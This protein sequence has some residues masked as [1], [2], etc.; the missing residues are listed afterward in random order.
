MPAKHSKAQT[1]GLFTLVL[2]ITGAI[3]SIRN[4]PTTAL[5]GSSLFFFFTLAALIFLIPV[6]LVS[7]E[8]AS[9]FS[10]EEG[11][12]YSWVK[13][14]FGESVAFFTIW[15]QWINTMVWYPTILSFIAGT[16]AY[17]I[18]PALADHKGYLIGVILITFWSL[19][20][21]SLRGLKTSAFFAGFCAIIGMIFPIFLIIGLGATWLYQGHPLAIEFN[22]ASL[23]PQWQTGQSWASLTAIM[24][25]FLG[26]ELAAVHV[27]QI[28][29]PQ[30]QFPKAIFFSVI[31]IL[32]T[33]L[34][35]SLSIAVVLPKKDINLVAGVMQAFTQFLNA[36]HLSYLLPFIIV[37][38]LLGSLGGMINW[39]ISPAKGMLMAATHGFL[40]PFLYQLNRHGVAAR[41]L[42][43]QAV[44]V[45]LLCSCFLLFPQINAIYW[46][47]TDL[48]TELYLLMYVL[49]FI[50]AIRLKHTHAHLP[51]TFCIPGGKIGYYLTCFL[52]LIGC[53][54]TLIIGFIP[55]D[56]SIDTGSAHYFQL[57]FSAGIVLM[58]APTFFFYR[59]KKQSIKKTQKP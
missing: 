53:F 36:F 52:G 22:R 43:I 24:T 7:A 45:T 51:R 8:L 5:F 33:M 50:A 42:L 46:L 39:I 20:L 11:G 49:M 57:I 48:S 56:S 59:Y 17:L 30:R 28:K 31:L 38:L 55:P 41:L 54:I 35:G 26:M 18:N 13:H 14:A 27:R 58:I 40:P 19:T 12:I 2:L 15:L 25:S 21:L 1:I 3:D 44:I 9:T 47:F 10:H 6:A 32:L 23:I 29:N 4:L 16:L 34:L 37:F